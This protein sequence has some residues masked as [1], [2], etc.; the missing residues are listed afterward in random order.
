MAEDLVVG[1]Q[2]QYQTINDKGND[3]IHRGAFRGWAQLGADEGSRWYLRFQSDRG[4]T[5]LVSLAHIVE[6]SRPVMAVTQALGPAESP[7]MQ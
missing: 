4:E 3:I 5:W 6:I 1:E 7:R 2:Y